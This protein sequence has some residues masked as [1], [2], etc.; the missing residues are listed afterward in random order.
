MYI[1]EYIPENYLNYFLNQIHETNHHP[2]GHNHMNY[3]KQ[4]IFHPR[5]YFMSISSNSTNTT[6]YFYLTNHLTYND[7]IELFFLSVVFSIFC[8]ACTQSCKTK[9]KQPKITVTDTRE[10]TKKN[11]YTLVQPKFSI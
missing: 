1:T 7:I 4:H 10:N 8:I 9:R 6:G 3:L 2:H 5:K 11:S